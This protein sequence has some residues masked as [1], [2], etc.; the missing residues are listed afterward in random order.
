M[1]RIKITCPPHT[2]K[3]GAMSAHGTRIELNGT[4][5]TEVTDIALRF[6]VDGIAECRITTYVEA[7]FEFDGDGIV[8]IENPRIPEGCYLRPIIYNGE[9]HFV[10]T[11]ITP[12]P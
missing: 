7:P 9:Q 2:G 8:V 5:I 11:R 1:S 12:E 4:E 6:P 3:H 10:V